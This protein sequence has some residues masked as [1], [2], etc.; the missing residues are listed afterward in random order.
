M[1]GAAIHSLPCSLNDA[2]R[3]ASRLGIP[4]RAIAL[5]RFP[6]EELR[7]TVGPAAPTCIIYATLDRPNEKLLAIMFAAEALR[8]N[9][10]GRLVLLAPYMCYMRQDTAFLEGEGISQKVIGSLLAGTVDR[11]ITV[12]A[13]LHRITNIRE[14]FP[15]I[16]ADNLS[17][18]PAI[19]ESLCAAG[20][21]P[22][23]IVV[24]PDAESRPWVNDLAERLG[25]TWA[26]AQK[27]RFS[28][29]SVEVGF[30]DPGLFAGHPVLLVDDIASTGGTLIACAKA[31]T[32]AGAEAVDVIIIHALFTT[33]LGGE[34]IGAGIRSVR[35]TTSVPHPTNAIILDDTYVAA[36]RCEISGTD[37][38]E[39]TS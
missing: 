38:P 27:V 11:I 30:A 37:L 29:R 31:L 3:I 33:E 2:A 15:G 32:T 26:V 9:G 6:D 28:D 22:R 12:D 7:V 36:L 34:F 39:P 8:R 20:L 23:T 10:A 25:L 4:M 17:A 35:S 1:S 24:G 18:M 5:H 19:A 16:E 13:H 14:A 21:D